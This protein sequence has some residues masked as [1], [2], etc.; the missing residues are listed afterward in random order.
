MA[1]TTQYKNNWQKENLDR[2]SLTVPK[3]RKVQIQ[4]HALAHGESINGFIVRAIG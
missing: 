3:G 2:I 1:G 4:S